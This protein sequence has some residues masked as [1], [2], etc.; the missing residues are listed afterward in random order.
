M[1]SKKT[2]A[3]AMIGIPDNE[4]H[5][6]KNIFKL[7]L[8]RT[9]TYVIVSSEESSQI[10]IVDADDPKAMA[11]WRAS[12]GVIGKS[13]SPDHDRFKMPIP[14]VMVTREKLHDEFP[15]YIRRP[16]VATRVLGVLDQVAS[17]ELGGNQHSFISV[18]KAVPTSEEEVGVYR[19]LVVDQSKSIR[20]QI[21]LELNLFGIQ[22]DAVESGEKAFELLNQ[23][24]YDMVFLDIV[25]PGI[26]GYQVCKGIK[27]IRKKTNVV[28]ITN[29]SSPFDRVKGALAGCDIYITKPVK[30]AFFQKVVQKYL[31]K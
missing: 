25:L 21:E 26:D 3:V 13:A 14:A 20:N 5:I 9:Q 18:K 29:K 23:N 10:L 15:Y 24:N 28:I 7:S 11:E 17:K 12:C 30:R 4:R 19:A 6:L 16:F 2:F 31:S 22:V 27:K 1:S 8:Y